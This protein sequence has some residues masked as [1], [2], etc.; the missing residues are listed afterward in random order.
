MSI[1][2]LL[3][4]AHSVAR[5]GLRAAI[6]R[7]PD[8]ELVGEAAEGAAALRLIAER[9]PDVVIID[10]A[11][12]ET[13]GLAVAQHL[14]GNGA[15]KLLCF[16]SRADVRDIQRVLKAGAAGILTKE[17]SSVDD[18]VAAIR[19]LAR[20]QAALSPAVARD[21]MRDYVK[22]LSEHETSPLATLTPKERE[23]LQLIAEGKSTRQIAEQLS[24]N[25]KTVATH[26]YLILEKLGLATTTDLIRFAIKEGLI[27]LQQ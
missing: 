1:R 12:H 6:E 10:A 4:D 8:M 9:A 13:N 25:V 24:M 19:L 22:H 3:V 5:F 21:M 15:A 16:S 7:Q 14:A 18:V 11:Q 26:R 17:E 2:V 23:V 27:P 20:G